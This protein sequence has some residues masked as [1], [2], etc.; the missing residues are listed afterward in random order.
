MKKVELVETVATNAGLTKAD[1]LKAI[2]ATFD[3]I[4]EVL[5]KGDKVTFVGFGTF[6]VSERNARTGRNPQ[7]GAPVEIPA[8][9]AV[10][11]K[12]G[13]QLKKTLN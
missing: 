13:N 4:T 6:A 8:R 1:A 3:A 7:T 10:V 5:K 12:A 9:K 11:F 2:D